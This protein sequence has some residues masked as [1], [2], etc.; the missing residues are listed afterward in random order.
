MRINDGG[1][2]KFLGELFDQVIYNDPGFRIETRV[3][4]VA[5]Q[6]LGI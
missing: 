3:W 4:F 1:H 2:L 6:V 5:E